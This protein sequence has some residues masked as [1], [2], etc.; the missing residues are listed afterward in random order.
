M[1]LWQDLTFAIRLLLKERWFT[2]AAGSALALGIGVNAMAFTVVDAIL[3]RGV[4]VRDPARFVEVSMNW[5]GGQYGSSLPDFEDWQRSARTFSS[6]TAVLGSGFSVVDEGRPG[7][8]FQGTYTS[9][10]VFQEIGTHA[11]LGRNFGAEEDRRG[12]EPEVIL[13]HGLW[14]RRY[15]A[16][17]TVIGRHIKVNGLVSTI[18]G[19]MPEGMQFP[20]NNDLW[21]PLS[22]LPRDIRDQKRDMRI[23]S[24]FGRLA[25]GATLRQARAEL[26]TI[27]AE[28]EKQYPETSRAVTPSIVTYQES[29]SAGPLRL[30]LLSMMGAV[31]FVLLIACANVANL[32]LARAAQ[33]S[34][35][36]AVRVSLGATR[37]R[38]AR[39]LLV[40]SLLLA[41]VS[42]V[43]GLAVA[44]IG[45]KLFDHALPDGRPYWV[46][47]T[48]DPIVFAFL[49]A[50][51]LGAGILFG[52]APALHVSKT[53]VA[54][55]LKESGRSGTIGVRA[56]RWT[57]ALIVT[58][59][60]LTLAL[61]AGAGFM[62]RSFLSLYRMDIGVDTSR[63]LMMQL[64]LPDAKYPTADDRNRFLTR[65]D[66]R[67]QGI[68][69]VESAT[70][71]S[72]V[73]FGGG[74]VRY[75]DV[76]GRPAPAGQPLPTITMVTVGARYVETIKVPVS[77][78]RALT[79]ADGLPVTKR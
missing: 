18:V 66:E 65:V 74:Q 69:A 53:G 4:P 52:L 26:T 23:F 34:S 70:T 54:D 13:A 45:I 67:L 39:Q 40:E 24:V 44:V 37:W 21:V 31:T 46:T 33:R 36:M 5:R 2:A 62:M 47:F 42:G 7:E 25:D 20:F 79:E 38:L 78:G 73:P 58:E 57:S 75:L 16:D 77:R 61:L 14:T 51:S 71:A 56:R 17:P 64:P 55:V 3:L 72:S 48:L 19:V 6:F 43:A 63:L 76:N 30:M 28:L 22:H 60:A 10:N 9:A 15:G 59:V 1:M 27:A 11:V 68:A 50:V 41:V 49:A 29:V 35:E 8:Q 32:L 12:A